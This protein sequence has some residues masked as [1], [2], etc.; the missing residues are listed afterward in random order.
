VP[1]NIGKKCSHDTAPL[2]YRHLTD[3]SPDH[4][5]FERRASWAFRS[6]TMGA[7]APE[8]AGGSVNALNMVI[9]GPAYEPG[10]GDTTD[11]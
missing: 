6:R 11:A 4:K 2:S 7:T 8:S 3:T 5:G 1:V 10:R 9:A